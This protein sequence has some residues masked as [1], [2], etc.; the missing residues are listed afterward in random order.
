MLYLIRETTLLAMAI[1]SIKN[2]RLKTAFLI[3]ESK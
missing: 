3:H 1:Y 2:A